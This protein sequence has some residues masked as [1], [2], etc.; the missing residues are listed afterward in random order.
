MISG[1]ANP[2]HLDLELAVATPKPKD[3]PRRSRRFASPP[4]S[5]KSSIGGFARYLRRTP[6]W[7]EGAQFVDHMLQFWQ[8]RLCPSMREAGRA[9]FDVALRILGRI[10]HCRPMSAATHRAILTILPVPEAYWLA[11][12]LANSCREQGFWEDGMEAFPIVRK[13]IADKVYDD[14]RRRD[15]MLFGECKECLARSAPLTLEHPKRP[16]FIWSRRVEPLTLEYS[17]NYAFTDFYPR[18]LISVVSMV[19]DEIMKGYIAGYEEARLRD[20][21]LLDTAVFRRDLAHAIRHVAQAADNPN[22]LVIESWGPS[23]MWESGW[24]PDWARDPIS[25]I[26]SQR[27]AKVGRRRDAVRALP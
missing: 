15:L 4:P 12:T 3:R 14:E 10:K 25:P 18:E 21:D 17:K 5:M 1:K 13:N 11:R 23:K 8:P 20:P 19:G 9:Y 26:R 2:A 6:P 24:R 27:R 7:L 22:H 16:F